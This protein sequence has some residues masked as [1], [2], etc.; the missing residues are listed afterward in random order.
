VV[1]DDIPKA[2]DK[3]VPAFQ[4]APDYGPTA[5]ALH[6]LIVVLLIVQYS[7]GWLMPD[8]HRDQTPGEPMMFHVSFGFTILLVILA[9]F[10]WRIA[11]PVAPAPGLP[12]WQIVAS[13]AVHWALYL[14]VFATTMTG[15]I[16]ASMRGWTIYLF[17]LVPLPQIVEQGSTWGRA[18]GRYHAT[19]IWVLLALV[20]AHVAAALWHYFIQ[21]DRVLQRMLPFNSRAS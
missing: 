4:S 13:S 9:R 18:F 6:W 17:D 14:A 15:W 5:R 10:G 3:V 2:A 12:Q 8:I 1:V 11:H 16:F 21:K 20:A 19:L 7:I